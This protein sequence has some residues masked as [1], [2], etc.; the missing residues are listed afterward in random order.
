MIMKK[1]SVALLSTCLMLSV[2]S[3]ASASAAPVET[4]H[5]KKMMHA[6]KMKKKKNIKC[7]KRKCI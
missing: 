4:K 6:E 7:M 2:A 3:A 1:L 5:E